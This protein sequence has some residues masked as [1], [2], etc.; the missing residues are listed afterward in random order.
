[1]NNNTNNMNNTNNINNSNIPSMNMRNNFNAQSNQMQF[2]QMQSNQMQSNQ[3]QF[4]QNNM[5]NNQVQTADNNMMLNHSFPVTI[6]SRVPHN[7]QT[8]HQI[9]TPMNN[10]IPINMAPIGVNTFD[11]DSTNTLNISRKI[12]PIQKISINVDTKY[13]DRA[14]YPRSSKFRYSLDTIIK[15]ISYIR[16]ASIEIINIFYN[17]T[18]KRGNTSF[19]IT[20]Q[21]QTYNIVI[22]DGS[23]SINTVTQAIQTAFDIINGSTGNTLALNIDYDI[24]TLKTTIS[25][26]NSHQITINFPETETDYPSL[27]YILGYRKLTYAGNFVYISETTMNIMTDTYAFIKINDY[28]VIINQMMG[29]NNEL[30]AKI[31]IT[32]NKDQMVFDNAAN[33]LTKMYEFDQP[34]NVQHFDIELIDSYGHEIN[35]LDN[36]YSLTLEVGIIR[37]S[38]VRE[39]YRIT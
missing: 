39:L 22:P 26:L 12:Q 8:S 15:N 6:N 25:E 21:T 33:Y 19:T 11:Y 37:D 28:G 16:L 23:Y 13:R 9:P 30:L 27:G 32:Q 7:Q 1:M 5:R 4:N 31:P 20:Y 24:P 35:M 18:N 17:L 2:N 38:A 10:H 3:M 14:K 36:D 34:V 29:K